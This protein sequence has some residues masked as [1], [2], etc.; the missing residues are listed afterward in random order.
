[1][2]LSALERALPWCVSALLIAQCAW[3]NEPPKPGPTTFYACNNLG[4]DVVSAGA[5]SRCLEK[6][7]P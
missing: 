3:R 7:E 4:C 6:S 5:A 2:R 1:M